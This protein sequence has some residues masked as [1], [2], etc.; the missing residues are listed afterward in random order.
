MK[1]FVTIVLTVL[2]TVD[3]SATYPIEPR[4]LRKLVGE[5]EYIIIGHVIEIEE[6]KRSD[7]SFDGN[8]IA[9]IRIQDVLKGTIKDQIIEVLY[10]P[11]YICPAP[12]TYYPNTDVLVFLDRSKGSWHTHALSYGAK[13]LP[14]AELAAYRTRIIEIQNIL[15][16]A[17]T[18]TQ[19]FETVEWLVKC[20]EHPATRWE[21]TYELS[22]ESDFMSFY[23]RSEF[24]P[25]QSMLSEDQRQRLKAALFSSG[26]SEHVDLGLIDLVYRGNEKEV[27][28]FLLNKLKQVRDEGL[29]IAGEYMGKLLLFK[30]TSDL[31]KLVEEF[32]S[33]R[34][35]TNDKTKL[36]KMVQE[37]V[38][39]VEKSGP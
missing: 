3:C 38:A 31:E 5:S 22:P 28:D 27:F 37:F 9:R 36:K 25:F 13:T 33:K 30:S 8:T 12:A 18:Y 20:A 15:A 29:W 39:L 17:D 11:N 7:K 34:F 32:D 10:N 23:A 26:E 6:L 16:I 2:I 35:E 14:A 21:G 1:T 24:K 19:F 4:P